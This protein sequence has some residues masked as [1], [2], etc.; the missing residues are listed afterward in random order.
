M[1]TMPTRRLGGLQ[2]SA[3]GLGEMPLSLADRPDRPQA[4]A[5]VRAAL[6]AVGAHSTF[7]LRAM[8]PYE[9]WEPAVAVV[10][11]GAADRAGIPA[12]AGLA[13]GG[14]R[15]ADL[16]LRRHDQSVIRGGREGDNSARLTRRP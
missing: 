1:T 7:T 2:V 6:A 13:L 11:A 16:R 5:T 14:D 12:L 8:A 10:L 9:A 15:G 4:I 3:I